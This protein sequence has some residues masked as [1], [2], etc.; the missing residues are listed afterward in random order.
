MR[1]LE[2]SQ[3]AR[4]ITTYR[5]TS[6]GHGYIPAFQIKSCRELSRRYSKDCHKVEIRVRKD[7]KKPRKSTSIPS[8]FGA[9]TSLINWAGSYNRLRYGTENFT[10][11]EFPWRWKKGGDLRVVIDF[12]PLSCTMLT[13][14]PAGRCKRTE[15]CASCVVYTAW[16][17]LIVGRCLFRLK[18][19]QLL[20]AA[21]NFHPCRN[22]TTRS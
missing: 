13:Y 19:T 3:K 2:G 22:V 18:N 21:S 17:V 4:Q 6:F 9:I 5:V 1:P 16:D 12:L 14:L 7:K 11:A 10:T 20:R 8:V 15:R